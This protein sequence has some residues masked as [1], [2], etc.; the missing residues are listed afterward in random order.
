[1]RD[2]AHMREDLA[3]ELQKTGIGEIVI[4]QPR[5]GPG[6]VAGTVTDAA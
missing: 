1:M 5:K 2:P 3:I 6:I 4:L